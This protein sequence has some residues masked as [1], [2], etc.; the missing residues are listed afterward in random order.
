MSLDVLTCGE[1]GNARK[2]KWYKG[3]APPSDSGRDIL[4]FY[5]KS[6]D[7]PPGK[8]VGELLHDD[9][10][11]VYENL[12][13]IRD[14]RKVL[15]NFW[16]H[17]EPLVHNEIAYKSAEHAYHAEKF[18][19]VAKM[20]KGAQRDTALQYAAKFADRRADIN[21]SHISG[22]DVKRMGGKSKFP[23]EQAEIEQWEEISQEVLRRI[24]E[25]KFSQ[26]PLA[27]RV[28]L[29]TGGSILVHCMGRSGVRQHW[30][31]LED[32]R[33]TLRLQDW[34]FVEHDET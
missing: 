29:A 28:L 2:I 26:C 4:M 15:S 30:H 16:V 8:G 27:N 9:H 21:F 11:T 33:Q 23:M 20:R 5:S 3:R 24:L 6:A 25:H 1:S 18:L 14:W 13:N 10:D 31:F 17:S 22:S 32:I 34:R 19:M 7:K 12:Q